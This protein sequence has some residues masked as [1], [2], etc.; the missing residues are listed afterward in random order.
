MV[1]A[2]RSPPIS[3]PTAWAH[4]TSAS[5]VSTAVTVVS[6]LMA[7]A[8]RTT[9]SSSARSEQPV[10]ERAHRTASTGVARVRGGVGMRGS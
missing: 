1:P 3:W 8:G 5:A 9:G 7:E 6:G 10:R 4:S 2:I